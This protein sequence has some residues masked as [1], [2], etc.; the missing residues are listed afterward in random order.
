MESAC[1]VLFLKSPSLITP[2][3]DIDRRPTLG[4]PP[5][6]Q[7][8]SHQ[9]HQVLPLGAHLLLDEGDT[10]PEVSPSHPFPPEAIT[11]AHSARDP[12][13]FK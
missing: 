3:T 11:V 1:Y 4:H 6:V 5:R 13:S 7:L 8:L 2:S 12:G 9:T 10:G